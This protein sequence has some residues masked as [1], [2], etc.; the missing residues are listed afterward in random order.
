MMIPVLFDWSGDTSRLSAF[1]FKILSVAGSVISAELP[2]S[3][4]D[5]VHT[6]GI[7]TIE[8]GAGFTPTLDLSRSAAKVN[9]V[10][11]GN[12]LDRPYKGA[13]VIIGVVDSGIDYAHPAFLD[14]TGKSRIL[15]LWDQTASLRPKEKGKHNTFRGALPQGFAPSFQYGVEYSKADI[16][17][18]LALAPIAR[19]KPSF[20]TVV[21]HKDRKGHG[22]HVAAIA[23]GNG[24]QREN[25][26]VTPFAGMAP[27]ADLVVV[28]YAAQPGDFGSNARMVDAIRYIAQRAAKMQK[29]CVLNISLGSGM[30]PGD[31]RTRLEREI[32]ATVS[33]NAPGTTIVVA[34]GNSAAAG[35]RAQGSV[36]RNGSTTLTIEVGS[37]AVFPLEVEIWYGRPSLDHRFELKI[38]PPGGAETKPIP[39]DGSELFDFSGGSAAGNSA[40]VIGEVKN[41]DHNLNSIL[42][43]I[44]RGKAKKIGAGVWNIIL[45]DR[46]TGGGS[47]ARPFD[48]ELT[49][50]ADSKFTSHVTQRATMTIPATARNAL[51]VASHITRIE[52]QGSAGPNSPAIAASSSRGPTPDG[53][54][55][56]TIAAPGEWVISART[57]ADGGGS[58]VAK[59]GTSMAAPHVTGIVALMLEAKPSLRSADVAAVVS[60]SAAK[61]STTFDGNSWGAGMINALA[62]VKQIEP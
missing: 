4:I 9:D 34:A 49:V 12:G 43:R 53:R 57:Y 14:T 20:L 32:E 11:T 6:L 47:A 29:N 21:P 16:D 54:P 55:G 52:E 35:N 22:T 10:A 33:G 51:S 37:K 42:V 18:A 28:R 60:A 24:R 41:P 13:G 38:K 58:Y 7:E 36:P 40:A 8:L 26:S 59:R 19:G 46:G 50:R 27:E 1:G 2:L 17:A 15:Y 25:A 56:P 45:V 61:P 31:G 23:A 44:D 62:A 48:A 3:K 30:L 39:P 5:D